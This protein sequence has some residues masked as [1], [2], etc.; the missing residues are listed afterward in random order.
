MKRAL[1]IALLLGGCS[2]SP[3]SAPNDGPRDGTAHLDTQ[4]VDPI[5]AAIDAKVYRDAPPSSFDVTQCPSSYTN[6]TITSSPNSRYRF[7][8]GQGHSFGSQY[9]ACS[10]DHVGWTHLITLN[11]ANEGAQIRAAISTSIFYAGAVQPKDQATPS[12]G[13]LGFDGQPV[14]QE[15]WQT[16]QPNDNADGVENNDQNVV[17]VDD[18]TGLYNDVQ[19]SYLYAAVCECDGIAVP[20][21]VID[22]VDAVTQASG[23]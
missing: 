23:H 15:V 7:L 13:W 19:P 18:S 21:N 17:A 22:I 16:S 8:G 2:F 4:Q 1:A 5:D 3:G 10:Q 20:Q 11:S 6:N 9:Y 12:T 14:P